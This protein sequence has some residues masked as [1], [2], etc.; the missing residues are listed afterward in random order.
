MLNRIHLIKEFN[1]TQKVE[2]LRDKFL[3]RL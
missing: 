3:R 2:C 1:M